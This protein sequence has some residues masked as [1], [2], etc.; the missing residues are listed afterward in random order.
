MA[1]VEHPW[2]CKMMG[3]QGSDR[4]FYAAPPEWFKGK[5]M[6]DPN[7]CE[8]CRKWMK[9]QTDEVSTCNCGAAIP[10]PAGRKR[11]VFKR[12]GPY[13]PITECHDCSEG[14]RQ[15]NGTKKRPNRKKRNEEKNPE[16][17]ESDFHKLDPGNGPIGR[18]IIV[19]RAAYYAD[20][21]FNGKTRR[22]ESRYT[23]LEHHIVGSANDWTDLAVRR[24]LGIPDSYSCSPTVLVADGSTTMDLV[25]QVSTYAAMT[26]LFFIRDYTVSNDRIARVTYLGNDTNL[27]LSILKSDGSGAWLVISSYDHITVEK[28]KTQFNA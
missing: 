19:D 14:R 10:I 3:H 22:N 12:I 15:P 27:E 28:I 20:R 18:A 24:S 26:D 16:K 2:E 25:G 9:S 21:T 11:H 13:E 17:R 1:R 23:H 4:V 8:P 7:K 6:S 5:K